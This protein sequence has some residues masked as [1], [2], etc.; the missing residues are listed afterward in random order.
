[1]VLNTPAALRAGVI[2]KELAGEIEG[3]KETASPTGLE[4]P[5]SSLEVN[6]EKDLLCIKYKNIPNRFFSF[7]DKGRKI[8]AVKQYYLRDK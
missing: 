3:D 4:L 5:D 1:M 6:L 2:N 8:K 7:L